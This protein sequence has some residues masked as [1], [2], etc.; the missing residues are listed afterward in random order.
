L[1]QGLP[2]SPQQVVHIHA[3]SPPPTQVLVRC[4]YCGALRPQGTYR[5]SRC[6]APPP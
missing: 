3:P 2:Q 4:Q 1:N 5:C 6:N